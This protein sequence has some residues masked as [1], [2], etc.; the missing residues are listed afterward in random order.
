MFFFFGFS[1][2]GGGG[3]G[4]FEDRLFGVGIELFKGVRGSRKGRD[5][6][7]FGFGYKFWFG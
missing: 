2:I 3:C 1:F 4:D 5:D 7:S 6:G